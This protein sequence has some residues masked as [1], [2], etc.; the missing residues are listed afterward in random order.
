MSDQLMRSLAPIPEGAWEAIDDEARRVLKTYLSGRRVVDVSGPHGWGTAAVNTG[1]LDRDHRG[2]SDGLAWGLREAQPLIEAR[3]PFSLK[4]ETIL[5]LMRGAEKHD[6]DALEEAAKK[7]A[8][9]E[10]RVIYEGFSDA[11]MRGMATSVGHESLTLETAGTSLS[12]SA[13]QAV[14]SLQTAGID[15]PYAMVL[16]A[17]HH[18]K[19]MENLEPGF[20]LYRMIHEILGGPVLWSP[21]VNRGYVLSTRGGDFE[22]SLGVDISIGYTTHH[23]DSVELYFVESFTFRVLEPLAAVVLQPADMGARETETPSAHPGK[24]GRGRTPVS[25]N[26]S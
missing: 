19:L 14:N 4:R 12:H 22:L 7:I 2:S 6:L 24:T 9:F 3:V 5:N 18:E 1:Y 20:P 16:P 8:T 15:G 11:S 21:A 13:A 26:P 10:E 23:S 25:P 17:T